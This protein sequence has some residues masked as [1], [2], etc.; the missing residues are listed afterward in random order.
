DTEDTMQ[1]TW[2]RAFRGIGRFEGSAEPAL[3]RWLLTIT[4]NCV[5][6]HLSHRIKARQRTVPI[7]ETFEAVAH[8]SPEDERVVLL[9]RLQAAPGPGG[10]PG[11]TGWSAEDGSASASGRSRPGPRGSRWGSGPWAQGAGW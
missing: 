9:M 3:R 10:S 11:P 6:E 8:G 7:D 1:E 4:F 5:N 2:M